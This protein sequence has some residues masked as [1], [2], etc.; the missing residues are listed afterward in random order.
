[1]I[2]LGS[3]N[4]NWW[5]GIRW[6]FWQAESLNLLRFG[7]TS[8]LSLFYTRGA[9][10]RKRPKITARFRKS[11]INFLSHQCEH[12]QTAGQFSVKLL[13]K[14]FPVVILCIGII[15]VFQN[16]IHGGWW[17]YCRRGG[18]T[19]GIWCKRISVPNF[20]VVILCI[21]II[22]VFQNI[23][24]GGWWWCCRKGDNTNGIWYKRI[25]VPN[26]IT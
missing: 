20:P 13:F 7:T 12:H 5:K 17:W 14:N 4:K 16:I 10:L 3:D 21:G 11:Y 18:G 2:G 9:C 15:L 25:S 1:M 26:F 8:R 6:E 23:I 22:L 24:H 19:D